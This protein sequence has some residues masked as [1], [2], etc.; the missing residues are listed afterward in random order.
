MKFSV[1]I[2]SYNRADCMRETLDAIFGQTLPP[3]EVVVVDDGSTDTTSA[4]LAEYGDRVRCERIANSG[5]GIARKTAVELCSGDWI[6]LCDSDDIWIPEFLERKA[7]VISRFPDTDL[8]LSN[9][10]SF[11]QDA[12]EDH[13]ILKEAPPDWLRTFCAESEGEFIR[14]T[15]AFMAHMRHNAAYLS[16]IAFSRNLYDRCGGINPKY[17]RWLSED[18]EFT[19]RLALFSKQAAF[20]KHVCWKYRRHASNFSTSNEH[21]NILAGARILENQL[22]DGIIPQALISK[23]V[24]CI[25]HRK[26][27]AFMGAYW[28]GKDLEALEIARQIP[29][30]QKG[31]RNI[32]REVH[33]RLRSVFSRD[34][35][36]ARPQ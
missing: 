7:M 25:L 21:R 26:R 18:F 13:T 34:S 19:C 9:F 5:P 14:F 10:T 23:V 16:G 29:T 35:A 6:A 3:F 17:S 15:N 27:I 33:C 1:A 2:P 22:E 24:E 11:G 4:L 31:L 8:C 36:G 28:K 30:S 20:D 12:I 32:A